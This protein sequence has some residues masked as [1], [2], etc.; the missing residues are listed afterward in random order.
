[1][2]SKFY[3]KNT[4]FES[5][6]SFDVRVNTHT[7][8]HTHIHTHTYTYIHIANALVL[9]WCLVHCTGGIGGGYGSE[10]QQMRRK[11]EPVVKS[12]S[13]T[14]LYSGG[15][16]AHLR[17]EFQSALVSWKFMAHNLKVF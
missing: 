17:I 8:T 14:W 2:T 15:R 1:M 4:G 13:M 6:V 11:E 10:H 9:G 12:Q 3:K 7:H 16:T 5:L